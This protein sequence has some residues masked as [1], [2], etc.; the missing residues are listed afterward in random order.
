VRAAAAIKPKVEIFMVGALMVALP[1]NAG[2]S[3]D[4]PAGA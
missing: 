3:R 4:V 1:S 2:A